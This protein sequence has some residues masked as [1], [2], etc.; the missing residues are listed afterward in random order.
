MHR[1]W[2]IKLTAF[3]ALSLASQTNPVLRDR[4]TRGI[5]KTTTRHVIPSAD[6]DKLGAQRETRFGDG[7]PDVLFSGIDPSGGGSGSEYAIVTLGMHE[8]RPVVSTLF[9][10]GSTGLK[11]ASTGLILGRTLHSRV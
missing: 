1:G 4:E 2:H 10:P 6:V 7:K 8:N 9:H 11:P 5:I 3:L